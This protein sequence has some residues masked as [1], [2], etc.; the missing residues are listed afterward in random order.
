MTAIARAGQSWSEFW[1]TPMPRARLAALRVLVYAFIPLDLFFLRPW[2]P[3]HGDVP[4]DLYR[5][6]LV[7]RLLP[8][9]TP[10]PT[11]VTAVQVGL[12][13]AAAVAITGRLPR[14]AGWT[15]FALYFQWMLVAFSY[16]KVD[17]DRLAYLVALAVIPTAGAVRLRDSGQDARAAWALRAV[18]VAVVATYF[19]AA[20]AKLRYGGLEWLNSATLLRA[21]V[22]RGT[23]FGDAVAD[24]P[25]LLQATQYGLVSLELAS[26]VLLRRGRAGRIALA[27]ALAFHAATYAAIK[28]AFW[29][30]LVCLVGAFVPWE[31]LTVGPSVRSG[32]GLDLHRAGEA[33][34]SDGS[35]VGDQD[36]RLRERDAGDPVLTG[37]DRGVRPREAVLT[38]DPGDDAEE[39]GPRR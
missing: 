27:I 38:D 25:G 5:P 29:P 14:A 22:R 34:D 32:L 24:V 17:H 36:S 26:P 13:V 31:R 35:A 20:F 10:T 19:L 21:V 30:H 9:P 7:G 18:Q 3:M 16:G 8:F 39:R 15:V 28:I 23:V 37:R 1:F 11:I 33:V 4:A 6:L 2:V 12:M